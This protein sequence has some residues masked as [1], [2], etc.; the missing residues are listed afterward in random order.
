MTRSLKFRDPL[1]TAT[2][3]RRAVVAM[4]A[5]TTLWFN[6]GTRCNIACEHC[7]IE[8]TPHNDRLDFLTLA[9]VAGFLDEIE[10]R[11]LPTEEIGFTG[12]E[13]FL[14]RDL[15]AMVAL[16]LERGFR[17]LVL[18][19]AM[20]PMH[21]ALDELGTLAGRFGGRLVLRVSLDHPTAEGHDR[22]RGAGSFAQAIDGAT[23]LVAAGVTVHIAGRT[24]TGEPEDALRAGYAALFARHGLPLDAWSR[25]DLVLF[26]E[27]DPTVD[28]PEITERCWGLLGKSPAQVMCAGSRMVV[29]RR[30]AARP[31]VLACT[32]IA[33]DSGFELGDT[34]GEAVGREVAL[35][36]PHCARFCVLGGGSCSGG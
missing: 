24:F 1:W 14:N 4:R 11:A 7:Y 31:V 34:L 32:L 12:G 17:V 27:M 29:R 6:T 9:E 21:R 13:V 15:P 18:T 10:Q 36:H 16:S 5:L 2:G 28:V 20:R 26:P 3:E 30:G 35:N 25:Q 8:S 22:E 19:N 23:R 33:Y